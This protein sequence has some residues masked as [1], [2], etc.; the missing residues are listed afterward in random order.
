MFRGLSY[1]ISVTTTTTLL[2]RELDSALV[3]ALA[4]SLIC[5]LEGQ[6]EIQAAGTHSHPCSGFFQQ[7][8]LN[9]SVPASVM[10]SLSSLR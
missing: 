8:I 10:L 3:G 7:L 9:A 6:H 1:A 4:G 2:G 5:S